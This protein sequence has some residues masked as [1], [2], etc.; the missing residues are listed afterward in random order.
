MLKFI[1]GEGWP[2][3]NNIED[4][5]QSCDIMYSIEDSVDSGTSH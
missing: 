5:L 1:M 2:Q 3:G 4:E